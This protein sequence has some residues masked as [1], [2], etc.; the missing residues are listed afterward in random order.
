MSPPATG[1][2]EE[3]DRWNRIALHVQA[4][5]ALVERDGAWVL[6][7]FDGLRDNGKIYT[8]MI[9]GAGDV[10]AIV[11]ID[12][13]DLEETLSKMFQTVTGAMGAHAEDFVAP[14]RSFDLL[15]RRAFVI[16]LRIFRERESL[17]FEVYLSREGNSPHQSRICG[18]VLKDV[19]AEI[20]QQAEQAF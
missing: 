2:T 4:A 12:S 10:D 18:P 16:N 15:A 8:V 13:G 7:K 6:I 14:L 3:T 11:R 17:E 19:A 1:Q 20:I 9:D 5:C